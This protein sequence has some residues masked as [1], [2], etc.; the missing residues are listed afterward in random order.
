ME[1][2]ALYAETQKQMEQVRAAVEQSGFAENTALTGVQ[3][4]TLMTPVPA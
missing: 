1:E 4:V 2:E 3:Q